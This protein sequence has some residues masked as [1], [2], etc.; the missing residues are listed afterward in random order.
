MESNKDNLDKK[1]RP[2]SFIKLAMR[3]M[4]KKGNKSL[5]HFLITFI[6]L[7]GFLLLVATLAKPTLPA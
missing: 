4:V 1:S 3:N 7:I 6:A 5:S 2:A